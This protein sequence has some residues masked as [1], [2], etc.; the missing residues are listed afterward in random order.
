MA[1]TYKVL[2]QSA[3]SA[4]TNTDVYTVGSGKQAI[5]STITIANRAATA[6]TYRIAIRPAGAT[7]A[8]QHYI[9]YD[10]TVLANDTTAL[11]LGITLTATDVVTVYASTADLSFGIFGSEI[12]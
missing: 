11:T 4:T 10:V 12:S 1:Y 7:I 3:P 2:G 6:A 5:I 8:N 9:A